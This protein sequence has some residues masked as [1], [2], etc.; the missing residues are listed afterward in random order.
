MSAVQLA[1]LNFA[2]RMS[3]MKG[4][5]VSA[6]R[7]LDH[8]KDGYLSHKIGSNRKQSVFKS[9]FRKRNF[10]MNQT[11]VTQLAKEMTQFCQ[12]QAFHIATSPTKQMVLA[13]VIAVLV[14][15]EKSKPAIWFNP[16]A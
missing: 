7:D 4:A 15:P 1:C 3:R 6:N 10:V 16:P 14:G 12:R 9:F 13:V 11:N 2:G 5:Y 8:L